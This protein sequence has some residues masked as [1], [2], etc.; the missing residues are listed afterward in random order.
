MNSISELVMN[1]FKMPKL[2]QSVSPADYRPISVTS[3]LSRCMERY[4]VQNYIYPV[5]SSVDHASKFSDQFAFRPTGSTTAAFAAIMQTV[6]EMLEHEPYVC[7]FA[8]DFSKAFDTV[9]HTALLSRV[10][11]LGFADAIYN[12]LCSFL[13]DRFHCSKWA[14][15]KS[16][17]QSFNSGVVQGSAIGPAA[18]VLCASDLQPRFPSNKFFKY[19]DD[20]YLLVPASKVHTVQGEIDNITECSIKYNL[21]LNI[22]KCKEMI[23][24]SSNRSIDATLPPPG[25]F[26]G[27]E[28]VQALNIL[29]I[30][31]SHRLS[32]QGHIDD[33]SAACNQSM[34]AL[35]T[36]KRSG[37]GNEAV[38]A[39]CRATLVAKL[40]YGAS[41]WWGFANKAQLDCLEGILRRAAKWGLYPQ[42][43]PTLE[44]LFSKSDDHLFNAVLTNNKHVL[45]GLLPPVKYTPYNLRPRAHDR[46]LPVKSF[47][48]AKNFIYRMIYRT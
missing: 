3:I 29:G 19:A 21:K 35:K 25:L 6:T 15:T 31:V 34:F 46:V 28:R 2:Q 43:G 1:K 11:D 41:A 47:T 13:T 44:E 5:L 36:L 37:L 26:N 4:L 20:S 10:H 42:S 32:M 22:T 23:I 8:L 33:L 9:R 14:G 24:T 38:W 7:L 45:H 17:Y 40:L 16:L 48:L 39:V 30:N 12:W 18:F 27:V